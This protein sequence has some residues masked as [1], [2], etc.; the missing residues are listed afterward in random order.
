MPK[1]IANHS[2]SSIGNA[3]DSA[4]KRKRVD[5]RHQPTVSDLLAS[6]R[7]SAAIDINHSTYSDE[8]S[9]TSSKRPRLEHPKS[10][11]AP[12][13]PAAMYSFK[14]S[15][16]H[17]SVPSDSSVID[18]TGASP[19]RTLKI[20]RQPVISLPTKANT[21]IIK[22]S[23]LRT[24]KPNVQ[25]FYDQTVQKL[26]KAL[27]YILRSDKLSYSNEDLYKGVENIC[28]QGRSA[29]LYNR[30]STILK[31]H[32]STVVKVRLLK[33]VVSDT[34]SPQALRSI[35]KEWHTWK[36]Q[37]EFIRIIFYYLERTYLLSQS[38]KLE[39]TSKEIF[40]K[41]VLSNE[42][43]NSKALG[44]MCE[45]I[46][47]ARGGTDLDVQTTKATVRMFSDLGLYHSSLEPRILEE[48]Q[49]YF[50]SWAKEHSSEEKLAGY[51]GS[52]V[53]L[54]DS[55]SA[56]CDD[57][58]LTATTK[59]AMTESIELL[60]IKYQV[61]RLTDEEELWELLDLNK[62]T[63]LEQLYSLLGR[64][65]KSETLIVP[66]ERW[67]SNRGS[68]IV[69]DD[70]HEDSMVIKLLALKRQIDILWIE[71]FYRNKDFAQHL[72]SAFEG[73]MNETKKTKA[74]Y[75]TGN[76][77][78]GEMIAKY[79]N[80]LL[81][82]GSKAIPTSLLHASS[83]ADAMEEEDNEVRDETEVINEQ[84]DQVLDLFRFLHGKA[85]FEAFYKRDLARRLL[86]GRSASADAELSMITRLK[87][88]C[89]GGFTQNIETM[90]KDM[91]LSREEMVEYKSKQTEAGVRTAVD[92]NV[93]V[94]SSA[95]W[96]SYPEINFNVPMEVRDALSKFEL[97]YKA[98][99]SS[100]RLFWKFALH[101][102]SIKAHFPMGAKELIVSAFQAAVLL[103]FNTTADEETIS[104]EAIQAQ[105]GI[106]KL[107]KC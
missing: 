20:T 32:A 55:E 105:T 39:D 11:F 57:I 33:D 17:R 62:K 92:L 91:D 28:R 75:N 61:K 53:G 21:K 99:H 71:S 13:S 4:S 96:P 70:K 82:G 76:T 88:E 50:D 15:T 16:K 95:A 86:L 37:S 3:S 107:F 89:G 14:S 2:R 34:P 69:F 94:L 93:H 51:V 7:K 1:E 101:H 56:R 80:M 68:A 42:I 60:T 54:F 9:S 47:I 58:G 40:H 45:L 74:N 79:V 27:G 46:S 29:D 41:N 10:A 19:P 64:C 85:V 78:Q 104:Y 5:A 8:N 43:L 48:S 106:R 38:K 23:N 90:F 83:G 102:T 12:L 49:Y 100:R 63:S 30:L 73:F 6:Q 44:G 35:L 66:F 18:L 103:M 52:I 87:N 81:E 36:K 31:E 72:R 59:S 77:K 97:S 24:T 22:I 84:L 67:I 25:A 26:E 65:H 98:H